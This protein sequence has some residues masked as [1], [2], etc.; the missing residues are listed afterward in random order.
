[1]NIP[2]LN[3]LD[4]ARIFYNI[5]KCNES[6]ASF[7]AGYEFEPNRLNDL[8][9]PLLYLETPQIMTVNPRL[10]T[11]T[12]GFLVLNKFS[13]DYT[14]EKVNEGVQFGVFN[15]LAREEERTLDVLGVLTKTL[16]S[17]FDA[18]ISFDCVPIQEG[19]EDRVFGW[20]VDIT[21]RAKTG[22]NNCDIPSDEECDLLAPWGEN[23]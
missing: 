9:Y 2:K 7:A 11:Y 23:Y 3:T 15:Y 13:E 10:K 5:V 16:K 12:I 1:M 22:L 6:L 14:G 19:F 4:I 20:R 17:L 21:I 8:E 18:D